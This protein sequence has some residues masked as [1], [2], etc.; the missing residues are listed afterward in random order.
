ME[1]MFGTAWPWILQPKLGVFWRGALFGLFE[2]FVS[3]GAT[4]LGEG[5]G[6]GTPDGV[7]INVQAA[8]LEPS[9]YFTVGEAFVLLQDLDCV[10]VF[11]QTSTASTPR[12]KF[13]R[14]SAGTE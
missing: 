7:V 9:G 13:V 4:V 5:L 12:R 8:L 14:G 11:V 10:G 2:L 3:G 6:I 1:K